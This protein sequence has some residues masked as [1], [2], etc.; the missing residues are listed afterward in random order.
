MSDK[1]KDIALIPDSV[2]TAVPIEEPTKENYNPAVDIYTNGPNA[3]NLSRF[4]LAQSNMPLQIQES[5]SGKSNTLV[6]ASTEKA[7]ANAVR[8]GISN[9]AQAVRNAYTADGLE[10]QKQLANETIRNMEDIKA[11]TDRSMTALNEYD[12]SGWSKIPSILKVL[13]PPLNAGD[14]ILEEKLSR[15]RYV[16]NTIKMRQAA[17]DQEFLA[18][19][20][21]QS[22]YSPYADQLQKGVQQQYIQQREESTQSRNVKM[23]DT[24]KRLTDIY[25]TQGRIDAA[26]IKAAGSSGSGGGSRTEFVYKD[27]LSALVANTS[28]DQLEVMRDNNHNSG[29][30]TDSLNTAEQN[31]SLLKEDPNL[32]DKAKEQIIQ[33]AVKAIDVSK[34]EYIT[35]GGKAFESTQKA[36]LSNRGWV[37]YA[38]APEASNALVSVINDP[39][40]QADMNTPEG[41]LLSKTNMSMAS[42]LVNKYN[43]LDIK[44]KKEWSNLFGSPLVAN[45]KIDLDSFM[46]NLNKVNLA[47]IKNEALKELLNE[48]KAGEL[49][50]RSANQYVKETNYWNQRN[51][52][53]AD[54]CIDNAK[55]FNE[56]LSKSNNTIG[57]EILSSAIS[58]TEN[59]WNNSDVYKEDSSKRVII[60]SYGKGSDEG[61]YI[62]DKPTLLLAK[63]TALTNDLK[64]KT[65]SGTPEQRDI[66]TRYFEDANYILGEMVNAFAT[67]AAA[68]N[69]VNN[70]IGNRT[71]KASPKLRAFIGVIGGRENALSNANLYA[72]EIGKTVK[73]GFKPVAIQKLGET[74][75]IK[76]YIK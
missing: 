16:L 38:M 31:I 29:I 43:E 75:V 64:N 39:I 71:R 25:A 9:N 15:D 12:E 2:N 55:K 72:T 21:K 34:L 44:S 47:S 58:A 76:R 6:D 56:L 54:W 52:E 11:V 49:Y 22:G 65:V 30:G 17:T 68:N 63:L 62:M 48:V 28:N 51:I 53:Y 50:S 69:F 66:A 1:D 74:E 26:K 10:I 13:I 35:S 40:S 41:E 19:A 36:A 27:D 20:N 23:P 57:S 3:N 8:A 60:E 5:R 24:G 37:P 33:G 42:I 73:E 18:R 67:E 46:N 45:G 59:I 4:I 14:A 61:I 70:T 7:A 32:S